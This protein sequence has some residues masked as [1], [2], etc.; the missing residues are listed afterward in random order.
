MTIAPVYEP[1]Q[2]PHRIKVL[3]MALVRSIGGC[4]AAG[5]MLGIT[6]QQVSQLQSLNFADMPTLLQV[7]TLEM[8]L[9]QA[10]VT[11]ALAKMAVADSAV[12][13]PIKEAAEAV[14]AVSGVLDACVKGAPQKDALVAVHKARKELDDVAA[15]LS[16]NVA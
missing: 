1:G 12:S 10:V 16:A 5:A 2:M 6:H 8:A 9:G 7:H 13:D 15:S 3:F 14:A 4:E 11:G